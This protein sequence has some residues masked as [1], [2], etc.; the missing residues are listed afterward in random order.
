MPQEETT[1]VAQ[2]TPAPQ[3]TQAPQAPVVN[4]EAPASVEP[5]EEKRKEVVDEIFQK[6]E[7]QPSQVM[8]EISMH[9]KRR[10]P[11][12]FLWAI[13]TVV[14]C[15]VVGGALLLMSGKTGTLPSVVVV[16]TPTAT[17]T[18]QTTPTPAVSEL[19]KD[20]IT[21]QVLNGGGVAGAATKMKNFLEDK[22][23]TVSDTGNADSYTYENTEVLVKAAKKAYLPL[24]ESDLEDSYTLG[25]SA[26]TLED[27]ESYDVRVIVGK[28]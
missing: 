7:K 4:P 21:I 25:T 28:E 8:P 14:A 3:E 23:Y 12:L 1:P 20:A 6:E 16:P 18:V 2:A 27:S 26:A 24:L 5:T 10:T 13:G 22:G 17:P 15:L 11:S 19:V 9:T